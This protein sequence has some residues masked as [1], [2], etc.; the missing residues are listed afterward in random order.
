MLLF[1]FITGDL[2]HPFDENWRHRI[3]DPLLADDITAA[4][5]MTPAERVGSASELSSR[6][7]ALT[8]RHAR[9]LQRQQ[10]QMRAE[11]AERR[12]GMQRRW[13]LALAAA[14]TAVSAMSFRLYRQARNPASVP[15][16]IVL[17]ST[18]Q[19]AVPA[20]SKG[21]SGPAP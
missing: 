13:L 16:S 2:S 15:Q 8:A 21:R 14:L 20:P 3:D 12:L 9:R 7:S 4:T 6:I 18:L 10:L 17:Q 11:A 19:G 1:R 5:A